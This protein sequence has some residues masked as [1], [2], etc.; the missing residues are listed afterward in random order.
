MPLDMTGDHRYNPRVH[1]RRYLSHRPE[2]GIIVICVQDFDYHDYE[3]SRFLDLASFDTDEEARLSPL[4]AYDVAQKMEQLEPG[5][6][7][8]HLQARR[9]LHAMN[10]HLLYSGQ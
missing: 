3:P 10:S 1:Y 9:L 6:N 7:L 5:D 8:G 4:S 2:Q